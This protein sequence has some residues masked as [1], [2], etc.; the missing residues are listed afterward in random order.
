MSTKLNV[1]LIITMVE[2]FVFGPPAHADDYPAKP[3]RFIVA[4]P[5]GGNSDLVARLVGQKLTDVLGRPFVID[6][7]GGAGGVIA[8]EIVSRAA[9]DGYTILLVSIAHIVNA[10]LNKKLPY[11]SIRDFVPVSL[12]VSAPNVL[13]VHNSLGVQ[14]VPELIAL[15]KAKPGQLNYAASH[16]TSLHLAGELFKV[17]ARVD[18]VNIN[19]KSGGLAV[20][21]LEAGRVQ[22]AFSVFSTALSLVKSGRIRALAITSAKRSLVMPELPAVAEFVPGFELTGWHGILAPAGT[23]R[24][25]VSRLGDEIA[26]IM[27]MPDVRNKFIAMGADPVGS[28]PEEF[29]AFRKTELA[30]VTKLVSIAGIKADD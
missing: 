6:N 28:T 23:S 9:A 5:A 26:K 22:M 10:S 24:A 3:V 15:A 27:H 13:V 4:F 7:R 8:E 14:S 12:V 21:D 1:I 17:M 2:W 29:A 16:G 30:K 19:Y 25:I 18:I 20:P 11:D